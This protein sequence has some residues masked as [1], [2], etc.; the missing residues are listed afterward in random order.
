MQRLVGKM[1]KMGFVGCGFSRTFSF[2][3]NLCHLLA[4]GKFVTTPNGHDTDHLSW[5]RHV[6]SLLT[7][8]TMQKT[9]L[10]LARKQFF[11]GLR[12]ER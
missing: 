9:C 11:I 5:N 8:S 3:R 12:V 10:L 1:V 7:L 6:H 4:D 2:N